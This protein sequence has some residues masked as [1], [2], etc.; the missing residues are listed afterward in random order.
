MPQPSRSEV[1]RILQGLDAGIPARGERSAEAERLFVMVYDELRGIAAR[2]MS[3]E[4]AGHTLQP[5][6]LVNEA[7]LKL[8]DQESLRWND[9]AHFLSIA[10]RAMRQILVDHARR[11]GA[12]KRGGEW[13]RV[14]LDQEVA[15]DPGAE[16]ELLDLHQALETLAG[17]DARAARVAELRLFGGLSVPE[18]A[19]VLGVSARTVDGDW[20]MARMWLS[21]EMEGGPV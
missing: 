15:I 7:Y 6:A 9:R 20:A 17:L 21:R 18:V 10:A 16:V 19:H 14:T 12:E 11:H 1:T 3:R 2:I 13:Q 4:R 8:V 5:T